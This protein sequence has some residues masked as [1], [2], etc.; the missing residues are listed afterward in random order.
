MIRAFNHTRFIQ[1]WLIIF[2]LFLVNVCKDTL[3]F[4]SISFFVQQNL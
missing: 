1:N 4:S 3:F 2:L